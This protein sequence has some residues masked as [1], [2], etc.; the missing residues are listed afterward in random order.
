[1]VKRSYLTVF[2]KNLM[3]KATELNLS[4]SKVNIRNWISCL[5]QGRLNNPY[6][7]VYPIFME[8]IDQIITPFTINTNQLAASFQNRIGFKQFCV[9]LNYNEILLNLNESWE[10]QTHRDAVINFL[11]ESFRNAN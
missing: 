11:I 3:E 2:L 8:M 9:I 1:M 4:E 7:M 10:N 6:A 5:N